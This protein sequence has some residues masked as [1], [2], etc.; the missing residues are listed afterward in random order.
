MCWST[1]VLQVFEVKFEGGRELEAAL[2]EIERA[3]TRKSLA[4]RVLK[5]TAQPVADK[6]NAT[7][8][9]DEDSTDKQLNE[10]YVV[11]SKLTKRQAA[12]ERRGNRDDVVMYVGTSHPAGVQQEFG[13]R[14]HGP[15][16]HFRPAWDVGRD[17]MLERMRQDLA[18]EIQKT[19]ARARA[20]T[21][22]G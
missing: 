22:R 11:T 7:A 13:N 10:S 14:R 12:I 15:Q 2:A 5:R 6:A 3:A 21:A 20:K 19:L 9:K 8:P 17:Q 18:M 4:R 1:G 16:P